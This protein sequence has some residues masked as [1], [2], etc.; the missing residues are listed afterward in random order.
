MMTIDFP[1]APDHD[2]TRAG[3]AILAI[4]AD[5]KGAPNARLRPARALALYVS[6]QKQPTARHHATL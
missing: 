1:N 5:D 3:E 4:A 2:G 6:A